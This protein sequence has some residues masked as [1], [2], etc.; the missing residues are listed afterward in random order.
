[1]TFSSCVEDYKSG[2][3]DDLTTSHEYPSATNP[4]NYDEPLVKASDTSV[5]SRWQKPEDV[6]KRIGNLNK[7]VVADIGAGTG[8]FSIYFMTYPTE[9]V[10]AIDID[11]SQLD[12]LQFNLDAATGMKDSIRKKLEARLVPTDNPKLKDEEVDVVFIS[13]TYAY[14]EN[15]VDYLKIVKKG[16]KPKGRICIVDYKMKKLPPAYGP[17][18]EERVPLYVVENQLEEAGFK[19]LYTDDQLLDFQYLVIAEKE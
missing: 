8:Y 6:L 18:V 1:M 13:N 10:I 14:L 9:K 15:K 5:R 11:Q 19:H 7:K 12:T 3:K 16:M 4:Y 17:P 2:K